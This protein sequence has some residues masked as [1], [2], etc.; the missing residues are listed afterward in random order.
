[1]DVR[2]SKPLSGIRGGA[3]PADETE[4][5]WGTLSRSIHEVHAFS[6]FRDDTIASCCFIEHPVRFELGAEEPVA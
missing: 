5:N 3:A 4:L 2:K 6:V 1:M